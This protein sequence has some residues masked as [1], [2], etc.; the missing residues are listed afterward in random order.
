MKSI[1]FKYFFNVLF[2][3]NILLFIGCKREVDIKE[4]N[5]PVRIIGDIGNQ[6]GIKVL[7]GLNGNLLIFGSNEK[8]SKLRLIKVDKNI[9]VLSDTIIGQG[10]YSNQY[11][12]S[13]TRYIIDKDSNIVIGARLLSDY[14]NPYNIAGGGF[15]LIQKFNRNG[16]LLNSAMLPDNHHADLYHISDIWCNSDGSYNI[17]CISDFSGSISLYYRLDKNLKIMS[18]ISETANR[19]AS[20]PYDNGGNGYFYSNDNEF[21]RIRSSSSAG[22]FVLSTFDAQ[23]GKIKKNTTI[24]FRDVLPASTGYSDLFSFSRPK[25]INNKIVIQCNQSLYD[26][27]GSRPTGNYF[28]VLNEDLSKYAFFYARSLDQ[29]NDIVL[30]FCIAGDGNLLYMENYNLLVKRTLDGTSISKTT[31]NDPVYLGLDYTLPNIMETTDGNLVL[32]KFFQAGIIQTNLAF[33]KVDKNGVI[34]Q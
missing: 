34:L 30:P 27:N 16:K 32:Y 19:L 22:N 15:S 2:I 25:Y 33:L 13:W 8:N 3:I 31:I 23:T 14:K 21:I 12:T 18:E 28:L 11:N 24:N 1:C 17:Q 29:F 4:N 6:S 9:N 10:Y 5:S 26:N 7:H 20:S